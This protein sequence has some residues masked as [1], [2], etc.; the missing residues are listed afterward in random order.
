MLRGGERVAAYPCFRTLDVAGVVHKDYPPAALTKLKALGDSVVTGP[1]LTN[2]NDFRAILI[3]GA[4]VE[5]TG[6]RP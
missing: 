1:T 5:P 6:A 3:D 2:V 4:A